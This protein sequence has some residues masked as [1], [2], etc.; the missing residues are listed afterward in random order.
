MLADIVELVMEIGAEVLEA[1]VSGRA[2]QAKR[3]G[4]RERKKKD[5]LRRA[6]PWNDKREAPPWEG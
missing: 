5:V 4:N 2:R 3:K 1:A 6:D